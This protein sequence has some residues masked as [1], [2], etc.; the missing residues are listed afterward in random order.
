MVFL[1]FLKFLFKF[2]PVQF[3]EG[4]V[5]FQA[6]K[7]P[8]IWM[9]IFLVLISILTIYRLTNRYSSNLVRIIS[10]LIK[11][12]VL[13]F[14]F[15]P[16]LE[17]VLVVP[18]I[19]P[20]EN[21][22]VIMVDNSASMSIADGQFGQTRYYDAKV[23]LNKKNEGIFNSIEN[24]FKIR[25]YHFNKEAS[26]VDSLSEY[27][28]K[29]WQTNF[30]ASL[31]QVVSD[32]KGLPLSGILL[33]TDGGDNGLSDM[34]PVLNQLK[35]Q[36]V[37]LHIVGLGEESIEADYELLEVKTNKGLTEGSGIEVTGKIRSWQQGSSSSMINVY[38]GQDLVLSKKI[39]L[40][41]DGKIDFFSFF[42][43]QNTQS[44]TEYTVQISPS[45]GESNLENNS[46][47]ILVDTKKDSIRVLYFQGHPLSEF[48]FIKRALE[49][50]Q[51]VDFTSISRTGTGKYYRQGIRSPDELAGGFPRSEAELYK[52]KAVIFGDVEAGYFSFEQ[53]QMIEKFVSKR[54]GGFLMIGGK[55][56]FTEGDYWRTPIEDILP[57]ELDPQRRMIFQPDFNYFNA[58]DT[59]AGY[60]FV[61]TRE[62]LENPILKLSPELSKN[63]LLWEELPNLF[64]INLF[65]SVKAGAVVLA[66]KSPDN[67]G[68][69]EPL[70]VI[71]RYG[72]GRTAAL[73][74]TSTWRWKMLRDAKDTRHERFW[75]QLVR[76]LGQ[77]APGI[78]NVDL[79][80]DRFVINE[81]IP[82]RA[83]VFDKNYDPLNFVEVSGTIADPSG[84]IQEIKFIQEL[85]DEGEYISKFVP[86]KS[87]IYLL[88][89]E[90][91]KEG[92]LVG[93]K[94]QSLLSRP[95]KQEYYDAGL[96]QNFLKNLVEMTGGKYYS[97]ENAGN[98]SS[99]LKSRKT[100]KSILTSEY[101]WDIPFFFIIIVLLLSVE[102]IYRRR[103]GL[104]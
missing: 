102:W 68:E 84:E 95:S 72:S 29:G 60:K 7:N 76:W 87:G 69:A 57:V 58:S 39:D 40:R 70:L 10:L 8:L 26:R 18:N 75:R 91:R 27:D 24:D 44:A 5:A 9:I 32:F 30:A 86:R 3:E 65:G 6:A 81:E 43:D 31:Q 33:F 25:M 73:A 59:V 64:S 97:P 56:S 61:P 34:N 92:N 101:I 77:D 17:P 79:N 85:N 93:K 63:N 50:D 21:F 2:N 100:S 62:G 45:P 47:N 53:L 12:G 89:V 22:V 23:L 74:T 55:N 71:Q 83:T 48:K 14:L 103:R 82:L 42:F 67:F 80:R 38:S 16:L 98:I 96:K 37:P 49:K 52:F 4:F 90:A 104:P 99:N 54:G 41:G 51:V 46:L 94:N 88:E 78:V 36:E 11:I 66:E 15:L 28:I 1:N 13:V 20:N 35:D 19:V